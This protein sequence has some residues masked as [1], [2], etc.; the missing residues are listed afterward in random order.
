MK[1]LLDLFKQFTPDEHFDAI[2]IGMASPEKIRSWSF[3]EVKKPETI[4]Y[5]TFKPERD[6]LFCAKIFGPIKDY[7]CL[8]GK[9]KRLK[10]R[11]VICEKCGVE[12][13]QTKV[14]RE[15]MGHID[16][17]APCAHIWFLKS[18]PSRLGLVLDMTLRDIER[19]LYFEAYVVTDPG[20]T[21]LKKFGIMSEDD[22][23]AKRKEYGDEFV[24]KMGAEGIKELLE[25][26]DIEIEI[27]KLRG[28]LTGSEVKVKKNAKRLKVLEAFKKSGI[29]PEWMILEVLPVLP[30]DLRPLVPL[31]GGRFATSDLNDLYRRVINRNSRLRRLLELKAPEIIARNEKRMLQ[32]AVDSLLDNGRRGKAMTG[33]NK[34]ALKSLADMIKGKSGRFRQNLLGKRVDYSGRSVITVGP[35]L[36]LHQCGLPKLMALELF[37]PFIF[38]RLEAMGIATTIKAAK[39]EVEAGTPVVWDILE[40]VIKEHPVMLNRAPTLHRLGIQAFEPILI[41]GKAIQLHPLVCAAFNAD[42]DG[43]QM[44]VHVPLSVEAQLEARTLMLASNNV[45]FPASGEPSIVPSQDVVLGLYHATREK[46]NGKGEGL[47]FADTGEV[48]R[49]LDAGEAELHAKISVRLTEWTK[50]KATGEFVPETKLVDTTVGRALLSE[51]LPKGLPFSNLNKA[52][53]KKEISKLI[54]ASFRKCG[55]KDTVVFADKLLQNGFRLATHAGFSV[56]IDDMLVPPQ[57]A[58]IL[59]RAEAEVKEIEQQYV[60]G[61]VTAGERYNKVVDIWGKAGDDVSKVMM[62]QLKVQ[63]TIDRNGKEVNEESFN[64][65]YMMA[66][67]GARGSAA[68]IRQLAGMRG[69]MA[70]PDGSIIETPITANFREGLN[71]L[72]YFISTHGARKGLA[73]TALKTANSGYLTRRLVDVTQDLVVTEDDCGTSNGSLM[74]AIVEGGEVIE[75]LRD[76]ILGRTAAEEVLHPETRAVLA[77][78][79]RMLDEDLIEE[80]EAAG[81]DEVKVRT[82][83]TCETRYGL[84]AKCY[85]RDL[86]RG[87]LINLGEAVGV[88]AAQSIGEPGTQLTM[89]TFHIGGAASRAAV[90]SSVEAKSNGII[91]FNATMRYVTNTK[92]E[93]VVIARSGEII[94]QDE[95]GRERE[96]HKVPYGATLTVKADQN[97]KAGTILANWDPLTRP[98]ITEYAGTVKFENVEEGLT[99]AKQV[100]EVTGLSTLVVIDPKRRG[101]AKVVRP[102]VKLVDADGKE[103]KIPGTDHS[104]TIGFQV[105][106]LIQVRDGQ[107]V[108]PGEVLARIPM[109]GQKTRDITGG[110]PRV[111]ELFEARSPKDKG[112][113][114]EMTG[115]ISF[116]KETKGKVR[117]Q[118]TDPDGK[119]W[120][121]LVPKEKNVLVHEGQ[122]VNKGELIVDGPADPQDILRLLGIE[123]LSRYIVDEVQDVY[124]LQGVKIND[125]HIEVIVRQMLRRVVVENPGEST[126]IA[127]EQVERSEILNTNE[128]LQAE[129]KLPATYSNVLLGIT[130]ASLSTDSFISAAS[131]QETTRV[132]TEAAIMG[133]RDELRGLKENVIVGRLIPAG[134]GLAYHQARKAKDA[135]DEAERRAIADAEAAELASAGTHDAAAEIDGSA[136]TAD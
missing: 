69:L 118:I 127:G 125:K 32:E 52:L 71:V 72:Q 42:F 28:D 26:I 74:R 39:K 37:K 120:D 17:A 116:G 107:E 129:G 102:Q 96:R 18:L 35:T 45:L 135:M 22:Y 86:G 54:N 7:E 66:D 94:I 12:V 38:S 33:A 10:H 40:E 133:K 13:T 100:D 31:D 5:R 49:A 4:N 83:L 113:L 124:R 108:G 16:L 106:A 21:P 43:D 60:S 97:I 41:E 95:H 36:K 46:I 55:L 78:P 92:G 104:V 61:L 81:V 79:G 53:K 109:E 98:I 8:C 30:P 105:G 75:S 15:R 70:K 58:E 68:Q 48:Q 123:E 99:V 80:L 126:Y 65:I 103:V 27:E 24:A 11:G 14:R 132:L 57:K 77:Q 111:A 2:K 122:V 101:S 85:G 47:V 134:T 3:G 82:A 136:D 20:M 84:C 130:K 110:L 88:I 91:G 76:R 50:D 67:S 25:G 89:R 114:A 29:K 73:D 63:K 90:A 9:Y 62:D 56:A 59:A 23:D 64:A 128:A 51:I 6:G 1:S 119:V 34:R 117:L 112:M 44:A 19:V 131:F 121:E 87:G 115:T 93:L